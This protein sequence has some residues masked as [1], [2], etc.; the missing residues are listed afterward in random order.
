MIRT[1]CRAARSRKED[2][3]ETVG[4][5]GKKMKLHHHFLVALFSLA[6]VSFSSAQSSPLRAKLDDLVLPLWPQPGRDGRWHH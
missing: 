4:P 1:S 3:L 5:E 6:F 2:G